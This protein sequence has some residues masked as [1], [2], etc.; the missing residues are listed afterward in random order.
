ML[1]MLG[2]T[3]PKEKMARGSIRY[4]TKYN[5]PAATTE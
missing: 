2:A 5:I 1:I 4:P 3:I